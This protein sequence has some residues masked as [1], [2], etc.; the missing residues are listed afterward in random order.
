MLHV[1]AVRGPLH[2]I[3]G[4]SYLGRAFSA[5]LSGQ[6][7]AARHLAYYAE[8]RAA[9][10]ILASSGIGIFNKRNAVIDAA[11]AVHIISEHGTHN[12]AW[13]ALAEWATSSLRV[14]RLIKPIQFAGTSLLEPFREFFPAQ[15]LT[16]GSELMLKWGFDLRQGAED[17]DER[18]WSSYQ[19]T[20]LLPLQ[21]SPAEDS[22]FLRMFWNVCRPH[23]VELERH[24]FRSLLE[25][26]ALSHNLQMADFEHIYGNLHQGAK[27]TVSFEF[28]TRVDD[29]VDHVFML[30]LANVEVP[31]PPYAMMCRAGLLLKL[32][33][34][35]AEE[36]LRAAGVQ[37]VQH[38]NNWWKDFGGHHGLWRPDLP[39]ETTADLWDDVDLALEES[40]AAP[41]AHRHE[42]IQSLGASAM[43]MCE[44][45]RAALWGLFP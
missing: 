16:L 11:G 39:P 38:F 19:P 4:W 37:P 34:G 2:V 20:A 12:M 42:W 31:A 5:L 33:T 21:T 1:I 43:R 15:T 18:N 35:M 45:E 29:S 25:E 13:L 6:A 32:A 28:L 10:S 44:T 40:A 23:G 27:N 22:E 3:D 8:L 14:E 41:K 36:N 30:H 17:R 24:L 7:H 26:E 9:L